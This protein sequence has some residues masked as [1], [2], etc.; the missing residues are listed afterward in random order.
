[1][2]NKISEDPVPTS[3]AGIQYAAI[4]GGANVRVPQ[5]PAII[6]HWFGAASDG[7]TDDASAIQAAIDFIEDAGGGTLSVPNGVYIIGAATITV[8]ITVSIVAERGAEFRYS[9]AS[10]AIDIYG[11]IVNGSRFMVLPNLQR[12]GGVEWDAGLDT[13]SIGV[14]LNACH[15][16]TIH[17]GEIRNFRRGMVLRALPNSGDQIDSGNCICNTIFVGHNINNWRGIDFQYHPAG[18][19][20]SVF[21]VNQNTFIGG[22][23]RID[24]AWNHEAGRDSLYM[25]DSENNMNTFVGV[26]LEKGATERGIYCGSQENL[27]LNC[28]FE[29]GGTGYITLLA[30]AINNTFIGGRTTTLSNGSFDTIVSNSGFANRFMWANTFGSKHISWD[31]NDGTIYF[32]NGTAYPDFP[33]IGYGTN[34]LQIGKSG[35]AGTRHFGYMREETFTQASGTTLTANHDHYILTHGSSTTITGV[36]GGLSADIEGIVSIIATTANV[37]LQHAASPTSGQGKFVLKAGVDKALGATAPVVFRTYDG[38]LYE[39]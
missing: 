21:G 31:F 1:M 19:G 17:V 29:G 28:R 26:N 22:V 5:R 6:P 23:I 7:T 33:I 13:T 25:P 14:R 16:D 20:F 18:G 10:V 38:N 27:W 15:Y 4:Q 39:V 32:G 9:G 3:R 24:S 34:R 11:N 12:E 30:A 36:A 2:A 8:P 37:T 35:S